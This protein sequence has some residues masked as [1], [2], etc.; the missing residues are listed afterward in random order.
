MELLVQLK[1]SNMGTSGEAEAVRLR[2]ATFNYLAE[3]LQ[4]AMVVKF[5][6]IDNEAYWT[7]LRDIPPPD[8]GN[9][10]FTARIPKANRLSAIDWSEI[11]RIIRGMTNTKLAATRG[12]TIPKRTD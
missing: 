10:T 3:R 2:T 6:A 11:Q 1:A 4:I 5:V 8:Q 9:E 7:L 12:R